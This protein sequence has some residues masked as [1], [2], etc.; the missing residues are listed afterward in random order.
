[1]ETAPGPVSVGDTIVVRVY[2]DTDTSPA[3]ALD[4]TVD[5]SFSSSTIT[6]KDIDLAGSLL[7]IWPHPPALSADGDSVSFTGGL[8]GGFTG[9]HLLLFGIILTAKA[10]GAASFVPT[11]TTLYLNDGKGT[12]TP[13]T[14]KTFALTIM[15]AEAG[16]VPRNEWQTIVS[17]DTTPPEAFTIYEGQDPSVYG[18]KKYLYFQTTDAQSGIDHYEVT[19]GTAAPVRTGSTYVLQDQINPVVVTVSAYDKAGNVRTS[20]Y[21]TP[22]SNG[23]EMQIALTSFVLLAGIC[24]IWLVLR[25]RH[26]I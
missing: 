9:T 6:F 15:P 1:M 22:S 3:N 26:R 10:P 17:G 25:R 18:G 21:R 2:L 11:N 20:T 12:A 24:I 23:T 19:E 5:F 16:V 8:P 4:G 13:V 14:P 7:T